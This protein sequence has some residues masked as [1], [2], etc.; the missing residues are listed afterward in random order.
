[1]AAALEPAFSISSVTV[2]MSCP[3]SIFDPSG[4]SARLAK[5][6]AADSIELLLPPVGIVARRSTDF[7]AVADPLVRQ[8]LRFIDENLHRPL[9]IDMV[10][11]EL[12]V[13]RRK[14]TGRFRESMQH[15]IAAEIQRLRIERVKR[16]LTSTD[17]AIQRIARRAGFAS[18]RTM[19]D[20]FRAE[21]GCTPRDYRRERSRSD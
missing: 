6:T 11:D 1:M 2:N 20:A 21:V 3:F 18:P 19:N 7:F 15:G 4:A 17:D 16:Q 13:S 8:A 5:A 14:L 12:E 10:A 9:T